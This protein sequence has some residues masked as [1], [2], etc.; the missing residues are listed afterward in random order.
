[1]EMRHANRP[2]TLVDSAGDLLSSEEADHSSTS[3]DTGSDRSWYAEA[4]ADPSLAVSWLT[5]VTGRPRTKRMKDDGECQSPFKQKKKLD[6]RKKEADDIRVK[7][8]DRIPV[9]E[10]VFAL[11]FIL[12][13]F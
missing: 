7:Y 5:S 9:R 13:F 1:M 8:P 12:L 11:K 2:Q 3:C 10:V 6:A 4:K